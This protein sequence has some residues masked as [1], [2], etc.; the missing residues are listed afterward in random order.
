MTSQGSRRVPGVSDTNLLRNGGDYTRGRGSPGSVTKNA[1]RLS[2]VR[3]IACHLAT[4]QNSLI[5]GF[6]RSFCSCESRVRRVALGCEV[7]NLGRDMLIGL[8]VV[9]PPKRLRAY[10]GRNTK[11]QTQAALLQTWLVRGR[12]ST[13][14]RSSPE[15]SMLLW[16]SIE[17]CSRCALYSRHLPTPTT[18]VTP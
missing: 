3:G 4:T 11:W 1:D 18:G 6:P 9:R 7:R 5:Q 13:I 8:R 14:F 10:F 15:I 17:M 2:I 16:P 12:V